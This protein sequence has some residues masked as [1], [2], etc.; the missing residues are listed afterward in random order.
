MTRKAAVP[1][2]KVRWTVPGVDNSVL[3]WLDTQDDVSQSLRLLIRESIQRDGYID[4][5]NR[6]VEQLPRRGRPPADE[7]PVG[8][9]AQEPRPLEVPALSQQ[10]S[11]QKETPEPQGEP[12]ESAGPE[13]PTES[14][15]APEKPAP[16]H[17]LEP[18]PDP[19]PERKGPARKTTSVP[20]GM[21]AFLTG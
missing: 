3:E 18:A 16:V 10:E 17:Q 9:P 11:R 4:V 15:A 1:P 6:P 14:P 5:V 12:D 2:R 21:D 8:Q 13:V 7:S 20:S 19:E